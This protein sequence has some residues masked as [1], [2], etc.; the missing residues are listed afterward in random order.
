MMGSTTSPLALASKTGMNAAVEEAWE[1][2]GE[3]FEQFCLIA[4]LSAP[5]DAEPDPTCG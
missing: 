4:G 3:S 1:A 5:E 2:V